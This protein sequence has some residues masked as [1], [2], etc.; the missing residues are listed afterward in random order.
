MAETPVV[1]DVCWTPFEPHGVVRVTWIDGDTAKG[2]FVGD[3]PKGYL[4]G[5]NACYPINELTPIRDISTGLG[6][7]AYLLALAEKGETPNAR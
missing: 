4:A 6:H 2:F 3:H 5:T 1:G 7:L